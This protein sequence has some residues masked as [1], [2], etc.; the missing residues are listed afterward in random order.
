M[1]L[2]KRLAKERDEMGRELRRLHENTL[3]LHDKMIM[4]IQVLK[5]DT[6][7]VSFKKIFKKKLG[8]II[9][10]FMEGALLSET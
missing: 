4:Q 1:N 7:T 6:I 8:K 3:D 9:A 2:S 10:I 5:T